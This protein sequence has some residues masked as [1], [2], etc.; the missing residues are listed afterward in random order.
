M[1]CYCS[2][3]FSHI[4]SLLLKLETFEEIVV[5]LESCCVSSGIEVVLVSFNNGSDLFELLKTDALGEV[6]AVKLFR[7]EVGG[8]RDP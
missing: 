7:L 5:E 8:D 3:N 6:V 2:Q 1:I 4:R